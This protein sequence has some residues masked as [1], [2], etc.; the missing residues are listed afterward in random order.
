MTKPAELNLV[1]TAGSFPAVRLV[2]PNPYGYL[3][4]G[5]VVDR[6]P[7]FGF[8][9]E[10]RRKRRLLVALKAEVAA[11]AASPGV[12]DAAVLK[13]VVM[14]PG[15]GALL[16]KRPQVHIARYDVAIWVETDDPGTVDTVRRTARWRA[17]ET[18]LQRASNDVHVIAGRNARRMGDVDHGR[19]GVFL[20][21]YFYADRTEQ[22]LAV[23]EY[24][25]G[26]FQ[27][28]TGLDN[29]ILLLPE[30]DSPTDYTVINHCRWDRLRDILP[31]L[32]FSR[33]FRNYVLAHFAANDTAPI[34]ILYRLA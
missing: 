11:L 5:A 21:N 9:F 25:A 15:R 18:L 7:P 29:S 16:K 8:A 12:R 24:T 34:P 33:S 19:D 32:L 28:Q 3:L 13:T 17:I 20:I 23:W 26:W 4:A 27:D 6:R 2:P 1:E 10:S 22:N 31:D 30:A 14:P